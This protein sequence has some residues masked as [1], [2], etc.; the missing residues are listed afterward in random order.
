MNETLQKI[1]DGKQKPLTDAEYNAHFGADPNS[2]AKGWRKNNLQFRCAHTSSMC[3]VSINGRRHRV[4][5][6]CS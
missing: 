1:I 3:C 5:D 4:L 6:E 2:M